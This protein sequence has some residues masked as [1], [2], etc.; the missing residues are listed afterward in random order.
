[1][2]GRVGGDR[3]RHRVRRRRRAARRRRARAGAGRVAARWGGRGARCRPA[4][5]GRGA[6]VGRRR[7]RRRLAG[8]LSRRL[9]DR[10]PAGRL[11]AGRRVLLALLVRREDPRAAGAAV[12]LVQLLAGRPAPA[13]EVDDAGL[14]AVQVVPED[15]AVLGQQLQALAGWHHVQVGG[16]L[17]RLHVHH[18]RAPAGLVR[19]QHEPGRLH[20]RPEPVVRPADHHRLATALVAVAGRDQRA[21]L[22]Q[23]RQH[24]AQR[25]RAEQ[26]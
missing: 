26:P 24:P 7:P 5:R 25:G 21:G 13:V 6:L 16:D 10:R 22:R 14:V 12:E 15:D 8:R 17:P 23:Q 18:Q 1:V 19:H 9:G 20:Q 4:R 3:Q 11:R 2:P